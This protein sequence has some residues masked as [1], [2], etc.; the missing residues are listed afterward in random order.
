[1]ELS[2]RERERERREV[3]RSETESQLHLFSFYNLILNPLQTEVSSNEQVRCEN[4]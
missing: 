3:A 1:M 4:H 2:E